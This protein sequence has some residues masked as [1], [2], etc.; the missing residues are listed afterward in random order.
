[1]CVMCEVIRVEGVMDVSDSVMTTT[2]TT[3]ITTNIQSH[4]STDLLWSQCLMWCNTWATLTIMDDLVM[5]P[6]PETVACGAI[7]I[8]KCCVPRTQILVIKKQVR[9]PSSLHSLNLY[10]LNHHLLCNIWDCAY[11]AY[12]FPL[13]RLWGYVCYIL[14]SSNRKYGP[15]ASVEDQFTNNG[16]RCMSFCILIKTLG[17]LLK[18]KMPSYKYRNIGITIIK[19]R[20]NRRCRIFIMGIPINHIEAGSS[21]LRRDIPAGDHM[22]YYCCTTTDDTRGSHFVTSQ[23]P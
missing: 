2:K 17:N 8:Y 5:D 12:P 15:F 22:Y 6:G 16:M 19:I 21:C 13:W 9:C 7:S 1:M 4:T 11:S 10:T 23:T 18:T 14:L 20:R 3:L